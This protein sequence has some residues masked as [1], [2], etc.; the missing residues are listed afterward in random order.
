MWQIKAG[1]HS[2]VLLSPVRKLSSRF[3]VALSLFCDWK[4]DPDRQ[5]EIKKR[6]WKGM[7]P[8]QKKR[9]IWINN[10]VIMASWLASAN[11]VLIGLP[12]FSL[13]FLQS[14]LLMVT[15]Q[16][17]AMITSFS[18]W[19]TVND[20]IPPSLCTCSPVAPQSHDSLPLVP[21]LM[22]FLKKSR[23]PVC[24]KDTLVSEMLSSLAP[25]TLF[26]QAPRLLPITNIMGFQ[27]KTNLQT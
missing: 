23:L 1:L 8:S 5:K 14:V 21:A 22:Y 10:Q 6:D 4:L 11:R 7:E 16:S 15:S 26:Y 20:S 19:E 3:K 24:V 9:T 2:R 18:S 17:R 27:S 25:H 13:P 12:P